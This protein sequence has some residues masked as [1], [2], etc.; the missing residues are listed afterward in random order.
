MP[1]PRFDRLVG[2][3]ISLPFGSLDSVCRSI[4]Q[5]PLDRSIRFD[6][7]KLEERSDG[8]IQIDPSVAFGSLDS[9]C[10]LIDQPPSDRSIQFDRL[11]L[12]EQ[13]DGKIQL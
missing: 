4:D 7:L 3:S 5:P 11:K 10:R 9:F 13:S 1:P 6:R 8:K 12:E 2:R